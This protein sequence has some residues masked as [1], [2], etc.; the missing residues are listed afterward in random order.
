MSRSRLLITGAAGGVGSALWPQLRDAYELRLFDLAP[1]AGSPSDV[2]TVIGDI[3]DG[4]ALRAAMSGVSA[5]VHLAGNRF[6]SATWAEL[7]QPNLVGVHAV[8]AAAEDVG[9][10]R[11]V[12]A[13]SCH[14]SGL[15]DVER[16]SGVDPTWLPR[17]CCPYGVSKVYAETAA[18]FFAERTE[19]QAICL[20]LGAVSE[21][22]VGAIGVPFWLSHGDLARAFVGALGTTVRYGTYFAG[23]ANAR[24]RWNL[25]PGERDLGFVPVDNSAD[26]LAEID[27]AVPGPDC[28]RG[29][30]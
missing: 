5:V 9:V 22:P 17:P 27:F 2:E 15:Y 30:V 29:A 1:T 3:T 4:D 10:P 14:A 13:S 21:R 20:R 12:L 24:T 25:E 23:S 28:Y 16:V 11:V 19:L 6:A 7:V 26:H 18:R 8:L